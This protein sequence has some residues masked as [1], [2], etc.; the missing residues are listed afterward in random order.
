MILRAFVPD[1]TASVRSLIV[2]TSIDEDPQHLWDVQEYLGS[3]RVLQDW[4]P[5]T[6]I[7]LGFQDEHLGGALLGL[8]RYELRDES[9]PC[10]WFANVIAVSVDRPSNPRIPIGRILYSSV[11]SDI[12]IE[13]LHGSMV[14]L[15]NPSNERALKL[16]RGL[17]AEIS[18]EDGQSGLLRTTLRWNNLA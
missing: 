1:D 3:G 11:L 10:F 15:V 13:C 14:S 16:C 2:T 18:E 5:S 8:I 6:R 12:A 17:G 9:L 7:V 4:M